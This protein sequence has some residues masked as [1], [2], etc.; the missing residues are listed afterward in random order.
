MTTSAS[1]DDNAVDQT[2]TILANIGRATAAESIVK[3]VTIHAAV[4]ATVKSVRD[5]EWLPTDEHRERF[6]RRNRYN[7]KNA[8]TATATTACGAANDDCDLRH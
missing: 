3:S 4:S 7:R 5:P 1:G 8:T 6:S 2:I